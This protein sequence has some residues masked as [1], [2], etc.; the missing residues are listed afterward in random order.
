MHFQNY[1]AAF[2]LSLT[3]GCSHM[4]KVDLADEKGRETIE[5]TKRLHYYALGVIA[6]EKELNASELCPG[7][8]ELSGVSYYTSPLDRVFTIY[9]IGIYAPKTLAYRCVQ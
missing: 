1:L 6:S 9:T 4:T 8:T 7:N 3:L 2:I 5:K